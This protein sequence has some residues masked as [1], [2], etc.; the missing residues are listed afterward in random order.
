MTQF[1]SNLTRTEKLHGR[2]FS[3]ARIVIITNCDFHPVINT[4]L[5]DRQQRARVRFPASLLRLS[6]YSVPTSLI[7]TFIPDHHEAHEL[8]TGVDSLLLLCF[9]PLSLLEGAPSSAHSDRQR[10]ACLWVLRVIFH[11]FS[12]LPAFSF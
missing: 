2:F 3:A 8:H 9:L 1:G 7:S 12:L 4:L 5:A 11:L 6:V 10:R